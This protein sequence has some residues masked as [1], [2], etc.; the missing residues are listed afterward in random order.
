MGGRR[1]GWTSLLTVALA[2]TLTVQDGVAAQLAFHRG[3]QLRADGHPG[4]AAAA[5]WLAAQRLE[6]DSLP[7]SPAL[8]F[9]AGNAWFLAGDLPQAIAAYRRGLALDPADGALHTALDYAR[10][11]VQY[12]P[13]PDTARL[14]RPERGTWPARLTLRSVGGY[15]FGGYFAACFAA[16]RWRMSH[17][18][19]WLVAAGLLLALAILP[20]IGNGIEWWQA[21]GDAAESVVVVA[22]ALPLRAGNGADYPPKLELPRGCEVRRLFE[23]GGWLQVRTGGGAVGWVQADAVVGR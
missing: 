4:E 15:A 3:T 12:P 5:F 8:S 10:E 14:L 18:R 2:Q 20:A 7:P 17:R 1:V 23:R 19:R 16:T 13:A 11:Q 9:K 22:R 21:Q 6:A